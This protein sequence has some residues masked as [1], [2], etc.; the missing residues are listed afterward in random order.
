MTDKQ[1]TH[2]FAYGN[3]ML[4]DTMRSRCGEP[5]PDSHTCLGAGCLRGHR[6]V[7][8]TRPGIAGKTPRFTRGAVSSILPDGNAQVFGGL[9]RV[10]DTTMRCLDSAEGY[11]TH[12][13][14]TVLTIQRAEPDGVGGCVLTGE[15]IDAWVYVAALPQDEAAP[16]P[17][18]LHRLCAGAHELQLPHAYQRMLACAGSTSGDVR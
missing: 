3:N 18:Y 14:R 6:L 1:P 17:D 12:Y 16:D 4:A 11:P 8:N 7:F 2:Y 13:G 9:Y 10:S 5:G 15:T